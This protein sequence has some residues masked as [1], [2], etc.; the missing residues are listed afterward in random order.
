MVSQSRKPTGSI[1]CRRKSEGFFSPCSVQQR[2]TFDASDVGKIINSH[3]TAVTY[4]AVKS[5]DSEVYERVDAQWRGS[6]PQ[7]PVTTSGAHPDP[8]E[9]NPEDQRRTA[10][11]PMSQRNPISPAPIR[12][13]VTAQGAL[14]SSILYRALLAWAVA[15]RVSQS[16]LPILRAAAE[17]PDRCPEVRGLGERAGDAAWRRP[18]DR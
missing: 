7:V 5:Y 18:R 11:D 14:R 15:I 17:L 10:V 1:S 13:C 12:A 16:A 2:S 4:L 8:Q 9:L 6:S 3:G